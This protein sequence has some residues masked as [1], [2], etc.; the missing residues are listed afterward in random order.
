SLRT[1]IDFTAEPVT[2]IEGVVDSVVGD[3]I[4]GWAV[5]KY[6][7]SGLIRG[8]LKIQVR[9]DGVVIGEVV[10]DRPRMDVARELRC[11]PHVAFEFRLPPHCRTGQEFTFSF[12]AM[13]EVHEL[14]GSPMSVKYRSLDS[15]DDLRALAATVGELCVRA[16]KV[17][18]QVR[19][20]VPP[21]EA[22][23]E[24]YDE[25]ARRYQARLRGRLVSGEPPLGSAPL[26][27]VI[28]TTYRTNPAHVVA[29]IQSVVAQ[30][31]TNWELIIVDDGSDSPALFACLKGYAASDARISCIFQRNNRGISA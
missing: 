4:R 21:T 3:A 28:M 10:G 30:T 19:D 22:T 25:W 23:V 8:G 13:P 5:R 31:Y 27:S 24:N 18:R 9:C 15:D 26:V 14:V 16:F 6:L 2:A 29:A 1:K 11:D 12:R 7:R 20:L 17:Q